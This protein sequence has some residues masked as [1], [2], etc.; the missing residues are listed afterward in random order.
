MINVL[1]GISAALT[2][3]GES[4]AIRDDLRIEFRKMFHPIIRLE[5]GAQYVILEEGGWEI[6]TVGGLMVSV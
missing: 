5:E 6:S 2:Y 1:P 3:L 4:V